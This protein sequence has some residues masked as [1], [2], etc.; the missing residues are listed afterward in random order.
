[1]HGTNGAEVWKP[2]PTELRRIGKLTAEDHANGQYDLR[3]KVQVN[4]QGRWMEG[5]ISGYNEFDVRVP[6]GT[7]TTTLQNIRPSTASPPAV[8]PAGQV[9][10]PGLVSCA[11]KFEGRWEP[12]SG[13]GGL[14]IVFRSGKAKVTEGLGGEMEFE[15]LDEWRPDLPIQGR[16]IHAG[17]HHRNQQ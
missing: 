15:C 1:M 7:I 9:P 17:R 4:Y 11:G 5:E 12:P 2:Y 10:K 8:R 6:G 13:L 3:D 16:G 14:R